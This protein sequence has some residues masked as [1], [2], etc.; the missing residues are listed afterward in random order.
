MFRQWILVWAGLFLLPPAGWAQAPL[1]PLERYRGLEFPSTPENF[2]RGWE[3]RVLLESEVVNGADLESLRAALGDKDPFVRSI[4]ARALGIR[5]DRA[6]ADRLAALLE[7]DA[8]PMVRMRAVESLG[9]LRARPDAIDLARKDRDAGVQWSAGMAAG[10]LE[11]GTD[12]A[13]L[14]RK[15]FSEGIRR[16]AM[17]SARVGKPAPDF[18]ALT[19]DGRTFKLSDVLGKKPIALYFAAYDG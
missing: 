11:S 12:H 1:P 13:G 7:N 19:I 18:T 8:E 15:A 9:F 10:Q 6:S 14:V 16:E 5:G 3:E 2:D 4:A 17:G